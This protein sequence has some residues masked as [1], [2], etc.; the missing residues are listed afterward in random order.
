[1]LSKVSTLILSLLLHLT[2]LV[3]IMLYH[4]VL[5]SALIDCLIFPV[6]NTS[7]FLR[8]E[9]LVTVFQIIIWRGLDLSLISRRVYFWHRA[10]RS[11]REMSLPQFLLRFKRSS[12]RFLWRFKLEILLLRCFSVELV[13]ETNLDV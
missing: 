3:Q 13:S 11:E 1:M 4:G 5:H 12:S 6:N 8:F 7:S 10:R 9:F 2:D